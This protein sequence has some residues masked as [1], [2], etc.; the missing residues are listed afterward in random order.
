MPAT[1]IGRPSTKMNEQKCACHDNQILIEN[2]LFNQEV[3]NENKVKIKSVKSR[4]PPD[5]KFINLREYSDVHLQ[6]MVNSNCY[7]AEGMP[8]NSF[9]SEILL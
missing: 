7:I 1:K 2:K 6:R 8:K 3:I 4:R 9:A 5:T